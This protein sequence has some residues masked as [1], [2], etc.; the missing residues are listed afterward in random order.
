MK[1]TWTRIMPSERD[2][3]VVDLPVDEAEQGN[4][5]GREHGGHRRSPAERV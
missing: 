1:S 3:I 2:Q 5:E 4:D